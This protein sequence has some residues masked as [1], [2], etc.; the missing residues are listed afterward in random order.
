MEIEDVGQRVQRSSK[1]GGASLNALVHSTVTTI[2]II[3][4]IFQ[5]CEKNRFLMI[6]L[7][8]K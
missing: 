7:Q 2:I 8:K 1:T 4:C 6:S 5:N 3:Y